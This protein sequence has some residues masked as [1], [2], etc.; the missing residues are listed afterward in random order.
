MHEDVFDFEVA[1]D[2]HNTNIQICESIEPYEIIDKY[3]P[4]RHAILF[5]EFIYVLVIKIR[6][7]IFYS[8]P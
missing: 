6:L 3:I 4:N 1:Y 5:K 8:H 2:N 7:V